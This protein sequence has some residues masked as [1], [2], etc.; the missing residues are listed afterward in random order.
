MSDF[1]SL[2]SCW[3]H[4][5][6]SQRERGREETKRYKETRRGKRERTKFQAQTKYDTRVLMK[7]SLELSYDASGSNMLEER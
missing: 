4:L 3:H 1:S 7:Q 2:V 6:A 5:Q